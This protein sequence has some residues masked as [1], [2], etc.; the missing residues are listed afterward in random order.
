MRTAFIADDGTVFDDEWDCK[1]YEFRK[2]LDLCDIEVYDENGLRLMDIFDEDAYN[3]AMK[4]VA[5]TEK[6]VTDLRKIVDYTGFV[7][8]GDITSPGVWVF[9]NDKDH[10][11]AFVQRK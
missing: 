10:Y 1:D 3:R 9:E 6:A 11:G 7:M 5:R 2:T 4:V 8:Y